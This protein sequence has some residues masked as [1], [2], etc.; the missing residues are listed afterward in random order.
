MNAPPVSMQPRSQRSA[1]S[2]SEVH[3]AGLL[4]TF[5]M[6]AQEGPQVAPAMSSLVWS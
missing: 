5:A 1:L 3:G 6:F 4:A 2:L